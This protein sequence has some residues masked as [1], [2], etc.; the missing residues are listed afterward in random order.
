M[1]LRKKGCNRLIPLSQVAKQVL[2]VPGRE[3]T[4]GSSYNSAGI[5]AHCNPGSGKSRL[6][7][8]RLYQIPGGNNSCQLF[9]FC[10][11]E[12]PDML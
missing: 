4:S 3:Q 12:A 9:L 6:A 7:C 1:L 2:V 8:V 11:R 5:P 10:E